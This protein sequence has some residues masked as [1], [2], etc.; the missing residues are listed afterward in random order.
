MPEVTRI[1]VEGLQSIYD[2][3]VA[4]TITP[5]VGR[6]DIRQFLTAI[7]DKFNL[8]PSHSLGDSLRTWN[9]NI[10]DFERRTQTAEREG[11]RRNTNSGG[12]R[13]RLPGVGELLAGSSIGVPN[14]SAGGR[15]AS[16]LPGGSRGPPPI[17]TANRPRDTA[18]EREG[19]EEENA[20]G[21]APAPPTAG[22]QDDSSEEEDE[23]DRDEGRRADH[24]SKKPRLD[25]TLCDWTAGAFIREAL[26]SPR[27]QLISRKIENHKCDLESAIDS[28]ERGGGNPIWPRKLWKPILRD[29]YVDLAE[30]LAVILD[31]DGQDSTHTASSAFAEALEGTTIAKPTATKAIT[32]RTTWLQAWYTYKE[33]VCFIFGDRRPELQ[34]YELHVQRLFNNYQPQLHANI[35]R[36]DRA[37]RQ[38]IGSRRDILFDEVSHPDVAEFRDRYI[39]PG[40]THYQSQSTQSTDS[41]KSSL[42]PRNRSK[43]VCKNFNRGNCDGCDRK[44]Q[45]SNCNE[46]GHGAHK[47]SKGGKK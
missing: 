18:D 20:R 1:T 41:S 44:H 46:K 27:H 47:C 43:E 40:G 38:L 36:Y 3:V 30:V 28:I 11:A 35:I 12:G 16:A 39:I 7:F 4:S 8:Y 14:R 23:D 17:P 32:N 19:N 25:L 31:Y 26:L 13:P 33:A 45:C 37:V 5:D 24:P 15:T 10:E 6:R 22:V 29:E 21:E 2:K 34:A 9:E 42:R